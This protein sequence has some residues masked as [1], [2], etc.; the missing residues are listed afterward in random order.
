MYM[1][2][3]LSEEMNTFLSKMSLYWSFHDLR[4]SN[5]YLNERITQSVKR[6]LIV[7]KKKKIRILFHLLKEYVKR[8]F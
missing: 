6:Q 4:N 8:N 2:K 7:I 5:N 3:I 1:G